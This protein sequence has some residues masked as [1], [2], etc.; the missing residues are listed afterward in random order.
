MCNILI[1]T[2]NE[3]HKND[4]ITRIKEFPSDKTLEQNELTNYDGNGIM[5]LHQNNLYYIKSIK[6]TLTD[7]IDLMIDKYPFLLDV[8][9]NWAA[10]CRLATHGTVIAS[11]CHPF[12]RSD[13]LRA[14]GKPYKYNGKY[15]LM[16][17]GT[18]PYLPSVQNKTDS[19]RFATWIFPLMQNYPDLQKSKD[20]LNGSRV[21]VFH[22]DKGVIL[23]NES[24][25]KVVG[26]TIY[27][28]TNFIY[29]Y[30]PAKTTT[31]KSKNKQ[32]S[33]YNYGGYSY[34][35]AEDDYY[36]NINRVS[37]GGLKT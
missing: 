10:H 29:S 27:A 35:D 23:L 34:S 4:E 5:C 7:M 36:R 6:H 18:F 30:A 20:L 32:Q 28:N 26:N 1:W 33:Y 8:G 3:K 31:S 19:Q 12:G 16:H 37:Y 9:T 11:N 24:L 25:F 13:N 15:L 22:V 14:N 2:I 21:V 17:N